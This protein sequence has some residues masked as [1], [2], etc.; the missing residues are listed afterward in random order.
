[1][2][3]EKRRPPAFQFYAR[4][5]L[6]SKAVRLMTPEARGG[7]IMLLCHAWLAEEP[8]ILDDDNDALA[9]LSELGNER[10]RACEAM[11]RR[12]FR[13]SS[14]EGRRVLVQ[15]RMV[16][17]CQR[18]LA[19][20]GIAGMGGRARMRSMSAAERSELGSKGAQ[21]RW[22][23]RDVMPAEMPAD[24]STSS[25]SSSSLEQIILP[26]AAPGDTVGK[27]VN[28]KAHTPLCDRETPQ[29]KDFYEHWPRRVARR[30]ACGAFHA[31]VKR[32]TEAHEPPEKVAEA[33]VRR[34]RL[35]ADYYA[36]RDTEH[37]PH[38]ATW[39]N[40]DTFVDDPPEDA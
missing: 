1:M 13:A 29:F 33:L 36:G 27:R 15:D 11:V 10:W 40:G 20:A 28:G 34:A 19:Y 24:A 35:W 17:T 18:L 25:S 26:G 16:E 2:P 37:I 3:P 31:A 14:R 8:G 6:S 32:H 5:F 7:Y 38:P 4:D 22:S 12:A 21:A 39:L 9:A 30:R 23:Q